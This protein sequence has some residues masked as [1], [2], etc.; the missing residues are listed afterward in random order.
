MSQAL[1]LYF[2]A[3]GGLAVLGLFVWL[4]RSG[5]S[6]VVFGIILVL[7]IVEV[8]LYPGQGDVPSVIFDPTFGG[9]AFRLPELTIPAALF[10]RFLVHGLPRRLTWTDLAWGAFLL[11]WLE[12]TVIGLLGANPTKDVLFNG[13]AVI[14]IGGGYALASR[15]RPS[16][17]L[18]PRT[19]SWM[20]ALLSA[21]AGTLGLL[22]LTGRIII[23]KLPLIPLDN[24]GPY[25]GDPSTIVW[26]LA[27]LLAL[28]EFCRRRPSAIRVAAL[29]LLV[30][31]PLVGN[32]RASLVG[33]GA[34]VV[35]V[36]VAMVFPTWRDRFTSQ[37][38]SVLAP[39]VGL[40]LVIFSG[41]ALATGMGASTS[42][43]ASQVVAT[44]TAPG[45]QESAQSRIVLWGQAE[46]LIAE[47][48]VFGWGQGEWVTI[49]ASRTVPA[50]RT[51]T[52][53]IV[54][55]LLL[56][57][58]L[59]GLLLFLIALLLAVNDGL[60]LWRRHP[61]PRV[62]AMALGCVAGLIGLVAKGSA[63]SVFDQVLLSTM[64]GFLLG[65]V[66]CAV[67]DA[68]ARSMIQPAPP[69]AAVRRRATRAG[70]RNTER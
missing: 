29:L 56:R 47:K 70:H 14:F 41:A 23:V 34:A 12:G 55:D 32:Q 49:P 9:Q 31:S 11:W 6:E 4:E 36:A 25:Q 13:K 68:S 26:M 5:R 7:L 63:E 3:L 52:H 33:L 2:I 62:A 40:V 30:A 54:L 28:V 24:F 18:S 42:A 59:V 35:V 61:D 53:N 1:A 22:T 46:K 15:L 27:I 16:W 39:A 67:N 65:L 64:F 45:K 51:P 60:R 37:R 48:P 20:T 58:G 10:A 66:A 69:T 38:W 8:V 50:V 43:R 17:L 57:N 44:F 21:A 19:C